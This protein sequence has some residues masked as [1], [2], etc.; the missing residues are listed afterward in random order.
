[1]EIIST[2]GLDCEEC[3]AYG[4]DCRGCR[5]ARGVVPWLPATGMKI[6]PMYACP[7]HKKKLDDCGACP[8]LPCQM[9][10]DF[11]DPDIPPE[12]HEEGIALRVDRLRGR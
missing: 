11:R 3:D 7:V 9:Y 4:Q 2:C 8:E 10:R 1:M 5:D 12:E 6:C